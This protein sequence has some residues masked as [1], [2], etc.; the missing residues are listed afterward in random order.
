[1]SYSAILSPLAPVPSAPRSGQHG[2]ARRVPQSAVP[3]AGAGDGGGLRLFDAMRLLVRD[4]LRT[5]A[6]EW[7]EPY[8]ACRWCAASARWC[9]EG[10]VE[11]LGSLGSPGSRNTATVPGAATARTMETEN[12]EA[13]GTLANAAAALV[14]SLNELASRPARGIGLAHPGLVFGNALRIGRRADPYP[15]AEAAAE[16]TRRLLES[17]ADLKEGVEVSIVTRSPLLLRDLD[18]LTDLDQKHAVSVG[19][20]IPAADPLAARRVEAHVPAPSSPEERFEVVRALASHGITTRV[21]CTPM[22]PGVNNSV[23]GLRRLLALAY[24]AGASDVI[25]APRHPALPPTPFEAEHL[26][27]IFQRLRLEQGFPRAVTGRG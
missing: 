13:L 17:L 18:L 6:Y 3:L 21:L 24:R 2:A 26:L 5:G 7:I 22:V 20:V 25:S 14:P 19:V 9:S 4:I 8:K 27:P 11:L 10:A 16:A 15:A 23:P 1:M 12:L